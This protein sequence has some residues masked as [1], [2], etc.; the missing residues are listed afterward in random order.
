MWCRHSK[1]SHRLLW[2]QN[3][4]RESLHEPGMQVFTLL[5]WTVV[6]YCSSWGG[7]SLGLGVLFSAEESSQEGLSWKLPAVNLPTAGGGEPQSWMG[8]LGDGHSLLY[9]LPLVPLRSYSSVCGNRPLGLSYYLLSGKLRKFSG[10]NYSTCF[11]SWTW[12]YNWN[13]SLSPPAPTVYSE[14][15][16]SSVSTSVGIRRSFGDVTNTMIRSEGYES[17]V[18]L[19]S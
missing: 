11:W 12:S 19:L 9:H 16:A 1:G 18:T 17:L 10:I 4:L 13:S 15:F 14:F 2:S 3:A 8:N 6:W 5:Y 7:A